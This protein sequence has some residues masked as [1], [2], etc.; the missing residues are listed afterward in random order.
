MKAIKRIVRWSLIT[1]IV[2]Y[3]VSG[4]GITE[5]RVVET[6]T[7]GLL[8]KPL[9]FKLHDYIFIPFAILLAMHILLALTFRGRGHPKNVS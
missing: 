8:T 4:F 9:A 6:M 2:L 7:F 1:A 5:F 3:V